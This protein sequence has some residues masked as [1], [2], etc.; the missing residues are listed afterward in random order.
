MKSLNRQLVKFNKDVKK[1]VTIYKR[2]FAQTI[3][4]ELIMATPV[5]TSK[6]LSNWIA[7]LGQPNGKAIDAYCVGFHGSSEAISS[8]MAYS[9]ANAV[10][11]RAKIGEIVYISNNVDYIELLNMGYSPQ[12]ERNFIQHSVSRSV[13]QMQRVKL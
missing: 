9:R 6:A 2:K 4:W 3:A 8:S 11:Q 7:S 12:A 5:D 1:R 10:I 13:E